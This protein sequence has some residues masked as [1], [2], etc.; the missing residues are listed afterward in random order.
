MKYEIIAI[1]IEIEISIIKINHE[2]RKVNFFKLMNL[3]I[4]LC[5]FLGF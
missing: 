2:G 4:L 3:L 1:T 5:I